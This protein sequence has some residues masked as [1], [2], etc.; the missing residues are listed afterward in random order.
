[1]GSFYMTDTVVIL[2]DLC[3]ITWLGLFALIGWYWWYIY[4]KPAWVWVPLSMVQGAFGAFAL[5]GVTL[6]ALNAFFTN[7]LPAWL[8]AP[9]HV[10]FFL[11]VVPSFLAHQFFP[12]VE[13]NPLAAIP[14]Y[15]L[16]YLSLNAMFTTIQHLRDF[17]TKRI[18]YQMD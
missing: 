5:M 15:G 8:M 4:Q 18:L 13:L 10:V 2:F 9:A 16:L 6:M 17:R 12:S 7:S 1:M 11:I 14:F 3:G